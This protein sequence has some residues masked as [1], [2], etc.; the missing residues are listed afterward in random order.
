MTPE[1]P[2]D[3]ETAF[4]RFSE[5]TRSRLLAIRALI[6]QTAQ[7][8]EGT[9]RLTETLK[10]GEP[11]YLTAV[12]KSGTTIRLGVAKSA[13]EECAIFFN[14]KTS[15]IHQF[16]EQFAGCF[17]FEGNRA[18]IIPAQSELPVTELTICIRAALTYHKPVRPA[19]PE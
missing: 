2:S 19:A 5:E 15:L 1:M 8:T 16:R 7:T 10:W 4:A 12:S 3:V 18:L 17:R 6:Y 14:C 9:G 11:A 13:P